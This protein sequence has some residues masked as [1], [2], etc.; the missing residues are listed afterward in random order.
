MGTQRFVNMAT[1]MMTPLR[2]MFLTGVLLLSHA[3]CVSAEVSQHLGAFLAGAKADLA[4]M[5]NKCAASCIGNCFDPSGSRIIPRSVI[6][7]QTRCPPAHPTC[8][9]LNLDDPLAPAL[10]S[11]GGKPHQNVFNWTQCRS[12]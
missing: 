5:E 3:T 2:A 6:S 9:L 1:L 12:E 4:A 7:D 8:F 10:R 11:N